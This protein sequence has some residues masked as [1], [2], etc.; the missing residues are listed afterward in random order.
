[1]IVSV[2]IEKSSVCE[3]YFATNYHYFNVFTK[4][5]SSISMRFNRGWNPYLF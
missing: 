4:K 5:E 2:Y 3:W 1:M